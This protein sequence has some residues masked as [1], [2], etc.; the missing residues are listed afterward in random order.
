MLFRS[1]PF[2]LLF[3]TLI[4]HGF[5]SNDIDDLF[6]RFYKSEDPILIKVAEQFKTKNISLS[7]ELFEFIKRKECNPTCI[8]DINE[9]VTGS[10]NYTLLALN[11]RVWETAFNIDFMNNLFKNEKTEL[12]KIDAGNVSS[13]E[14]YFDH[15]RRID[16]LIDIKLS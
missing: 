9:I 14:E 1:V 11:E 8:W 3:N 5:L 7:A 4:Q 2:P 16:Q 12:D 13:Q 10:W 15:L 6:D